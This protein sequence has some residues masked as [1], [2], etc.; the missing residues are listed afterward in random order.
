MSK[1]FYNFVVDGKE[2]SNWS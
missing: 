1:N 2:D